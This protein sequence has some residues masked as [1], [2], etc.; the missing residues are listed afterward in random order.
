MLGRSQRVQAGQASE[1]FA[2]NRFDGYG[3][4]RRQMVRIP[5]TLLAFFIVH[6]R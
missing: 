4:A 2:R 5:A 1:A 3:Q 6:A